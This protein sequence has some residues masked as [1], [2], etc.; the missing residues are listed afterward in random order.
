M[1][2]MNGCLDQEAIVLEG[3]DGDLF[4]PM[5]DGPNVAHPGVLGLVTQ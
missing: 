5:E 3:I 4:G 1:E 2:V